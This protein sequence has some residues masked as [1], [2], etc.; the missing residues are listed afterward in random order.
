VATVLWGKR[1]GDVQYGSRAYWMR[2]IPIGA[3]TMQVWGSAYFAPGDLIQTT[4][5]ILRVVGC[6]PDRLGVAD[7]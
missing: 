6:E 1:R 7:L 3:R 2:R 4:S 5:G